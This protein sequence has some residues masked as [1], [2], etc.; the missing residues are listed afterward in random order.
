MSFLSGLH[1]GGITDDGLMAYFGAPV[2]QPDHANRA[3]MCALD[4]QQALAELNRDFE[5]R[6]MTPL[7]MGVGAHSGSVILGDIGAA[8]R[9]EFTAIGDTVNV[10][11]RVEQLTKVC[12]APV[13]VTDETRR[14][15]G[16]DLD[17]TAVEPLAV[18]GKSA[19]L[20]TYRVA[21]RPSDTGR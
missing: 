20:Q 10:A 3:V 11:A 14:R 19:P 18:K 9:R 2:E 5:R 7:R 1:L 6:G 12:G 16:R 21:P 13:L 17:F 8:R 4:M 15:V